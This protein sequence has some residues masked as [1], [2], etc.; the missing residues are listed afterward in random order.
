MVLKNKIAKNVTENLSNNNIFINVVSDEVT[1]K[2]VVDSYE[3]KNKLEDIIWGISGVK[4]VNNELAI[5]N[6]N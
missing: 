4:S 2:G 1:L 3:I 5:Y 6:E